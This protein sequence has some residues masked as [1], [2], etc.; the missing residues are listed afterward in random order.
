M[1]ETYWLART[2]LL[3]GKEKVEA[4]RGKHVLIAGLG[5]VG[6]YAAEAI[7][8]AGVGEMTLVD[9]DVVKPS[10]RNRQLLALKSTEEKDKVDLMADRLHDINPNLVLHPVKSFLKDEKIPELLEGSF[11]YIVDAIDT[12]SPKIYFIKNCLERGFPLVSSMGA[13]GRMDPSRI[14]VDDL[15]ASHGCTFAQV[16]RK[17]LHGLGIRSGFKVVF[18][19][20]PVPKQA[21]LLTDSEQNKKST[22]GTIS[23]MPAMFGLTAASVVIRALL[24]AHDSTIG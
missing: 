16:V 5:G 7:A 2:E 11:D 13:G 12:L 4:L 24:T 19:S 10:N 1:D 21:V 18:S 23:Y 6:G 20:E 22:V 3:L 8:R 17:K 15:S 14:Q 9:S